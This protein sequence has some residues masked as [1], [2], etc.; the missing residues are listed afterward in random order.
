MKQEPLWKAKQ[1][2]VR[3]LELISSTDDLKNA[4]LRRDVRSLGVLLGRVLKE[5]EGEELFQNVERLRE[6]L[7]RHREI[8]EEKGR[9]EELMRSARE[10]VGGLSLRDA[11]KIT[12]AFAIYF[13]LTNLAETNHRKRRRRA[14][15]L[16]S[17]RAPQPGSFRG[18]LLRMKNS[19]I[20]CK[21]A[22]ELF[23]RISITPVFTAHPTEVARRTVLFARGRIARELER[24]D[25]VP[26]S[27]RFAAER[28]QAIASEITM[29]WQT[30][31]VRRKQPTVS[32]EIRMG[33]DYYRIS[34]LNSVP[35]LYEELAD[36]F[37]DVYGAEIRASELSCVISFGSWIG[38]DRDGN[39]FVTHQCTADALG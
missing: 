13:E 28:E 15:L 30:D 34:L 27:D 21:Q 2:S 31:E 19:G 38:G 3:L 14:N 18:T 8:E 1:E 17:E 4:P 29:L 20:S 23:R 9:E 33:L 36:A 24:L 37:R 22:L 39:P 12:K 26:L 10:L 32:D 16:D 7:T 35:H 25:S 6:A 5:Q 11:H